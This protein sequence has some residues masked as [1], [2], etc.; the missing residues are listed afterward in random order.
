MECDRRLL[1]CHRAGC[2]PLEASSSRHE[3]TGAKWD[4]PSLVFS[5]RAVATLLTPLLS[6]FVPGL[7]LDSLPPHWPLHLSLRAG[8]QELVQAHHLRREGLAGDVSE[9]SLHLPQR[10]LPSPRSG[11]SPPT[12][13]RALVC[14]LRL[15][16]T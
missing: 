3:E 5:L 11:S 14:L 9:G 6:H 7:F 12:R 10:S 16:T 15:R 13:S 1:L 2:D 4:L 8:Q